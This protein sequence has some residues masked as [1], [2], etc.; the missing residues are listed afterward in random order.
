MDVS[1]I[2]H[3]IIEVRYI[4]SQAEAAFSIIGELLS[5]GAENK[6]EAEFYINKV[7]KGAEAT[8]SGKLIRDWNE[9]IEKETRQNI[10]YLKHLMKE[11][12]VNTI[13]E[14]ISSINDVEFEKMLQ[15]WK[16]PSDQPP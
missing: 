13:E 1:L 3:D 11:R 8:F 6:E 2:K 4:G 9:D 16:Q 12:R 7:L 10:D 5:Y 14:L 15:E